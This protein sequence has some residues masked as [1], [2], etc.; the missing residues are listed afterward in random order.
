MDIWSTVCCMFVYLDHSVIVGP[1]N[2]QLMPLLLSIVIFTYF[3]A[4]RYLDRS[5]VIRGYPIILLSR[6][7]NCHYLGD[8][9]TILFELAADI[10][11]IL[12]L[13]TLGIY[14]V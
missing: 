4:F 6:V 12:L 10:W 13:L 8:I 14:L 7:F 1:R 11:I 5:V 9:Q 3:F 2:N